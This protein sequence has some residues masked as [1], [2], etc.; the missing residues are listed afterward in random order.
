MHPGSQSVRII[1]AGCAWIG[2][3]AAGWASRPG[4]APRTVHAVAA[5]DRPVSTAPVPATHAA[6]TRP[7][8]RSGA[9]PRHVLYPNMVLTDEE[10]QIMKMTPEEAIA[11]GDA[12]GASEQHIARCREL[13]PEPPELCTRL[14]V[15][16]HH[17]RLADIKNLREFLS[18]TLE[19]SAFQEQH[20]RNMLAWQLEL[21]GELSPEQMMQYPGIEPGDDPFL[22][23][24]AWGVGLPPG[25]T[26]GEDILMRQ[27]GEGTDVNVP[28]G[29]RDPW[30]YAKKVAHGEEP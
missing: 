3:F 8:V 29:P 16:M 2:C 24:T 6:R 5:F 22:V 19:A 18:G 4:S 26:M 1:V 9:A 11:K 20:H 13:M 10:Q 23:V 7:P 25:F 17:L 28:E 21:E 30:T 27:Q 15:T 12:M 14:D